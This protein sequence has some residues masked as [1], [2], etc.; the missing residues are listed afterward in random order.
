MAT[1]EQREKRAAAM[2][3]WRLANP[4]KAAAIRRASYLKHAEERRAHERERRVANAEEIRGKEKLRREQRTPEQRAAHKQK[5]HEWYERN[6]EKQREQG[7]AWAAANRDKM[8]GYYRAWEARDPKR[9]ML[10]KAKH[11]AK[12]RGI[13]FTITEADIEWPT[14]CPVF[15]IELCYERDKKMPQ[16]DNYPTFDRRDNSK[17]YV[18]GNVFVVSWRANRAKWDMP[19]KEVEALL[20]YMKGQIAPSLTSS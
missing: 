1:Q 14:H 18:P 4:E 3:A 13:E 6:K 10:Q 5:Q 9:A 2:R 15:G 12:Q 19:V 7:K 11:S 8:R 17:G 16:R 20:A